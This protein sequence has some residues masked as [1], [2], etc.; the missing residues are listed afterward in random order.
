MSTPSIKVGQG[1]W[2]IKAGNLLGYANTDKKYVARGFTVG[3]LLDTAT[4]VNASGN[5]EGVNANIPRIDYFGGQAS[6]LVE[7]SSANSMLYSQAINSWTIMLYLQVEPKMQV[8][9]SRQR[10]EIL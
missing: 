3:R 6:L 7:L 5:I 9:F 2:G 1:N 4:R 8:T 10:V